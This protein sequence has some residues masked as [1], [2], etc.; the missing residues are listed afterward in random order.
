MVSGEAS[1]RRVIGRGFVLVA[2]FCGGCASQL[3]VTRA[4]PHPDVRL[5]ANGRS[6]SLEFAPTVQDAFDLPDSSGVEIWNWWFDSVHV[7]QWHSTLASGFRN[8][9][10]PHFGSGPVDLVLYLVE[11]T[12]AI[13]STTFRGKWRHSSTP[14]VGAQVRYRAQ[15]RDA[16]GTVLA[17]CTG[18]SNSR[19]PAQTEEEMTQTVGSAA[20]TIHEGIA[21]DCITRAFAQA[22]R[23]W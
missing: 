3:L 4:E 22:S 9:L 8:G 15:I 17:R 6:L 21:R 7:T 11:A 18:T 20:E 1:A 19:R 12:P 2:L 14:V 13:T 23:P 16:T 5:P 10:A